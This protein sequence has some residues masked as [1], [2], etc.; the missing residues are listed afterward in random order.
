V[1]IEST[2]S[3]CHHHRPLRALSRFGPPIALMAVIFFLSAQ[4]DAA[5]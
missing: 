4:P 5:E 2:L 3:S 1:V